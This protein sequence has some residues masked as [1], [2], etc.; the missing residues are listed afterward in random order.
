MRLRTMRRLCWRWAKLRYS[1]GITPRRQRIWSGVQLQPTAWRAHYLAGL[2]SY[3]MRDY[4]KALEEAQAAVAS[5]QDKTGGSLLLVGQA[6]AALHQRD[7]ALATFNQ[8]LKEQLDS[9][10]V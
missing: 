9:S 10:K 4:E 7:A 6:Q 8:I 3:Q 1:S 5:G 2:A